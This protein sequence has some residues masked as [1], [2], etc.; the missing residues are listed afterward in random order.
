MFE[1]QVFSCIP[2]F[3]DE[4]TFKFIYIGNV[5]LKI[6]PVQQMYKRLFFLLSGEQIWEY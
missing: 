6:N 5:M 2:I 1:E 4:N 3:N